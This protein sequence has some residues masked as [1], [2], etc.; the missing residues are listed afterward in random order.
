[1]QGLI[2]QISTASQSLTPIPT[3]L[4]PRL[5]TIPSIRCV[6]F[7]VYGTLMVSGVGDISHSSDANRGS[8]IQRVAA[9]YGISWK[10]PLRDLG[11]SFKA[12]IREHHQILKSKGIE[13][14]EIDIRE[15][16]SDFLQQHAVSPSPRWDDQIEAISL[17]FELAVNPTWPM[18]GLASTLEDLRNRN[19]AL[20]IVS[21]AQFFTPLLF[22]AYLETSLENLGFSSELCQWSYL[23]REAKPSTTLY[24]HNVE[25]LRQRHISPP[26]VLYVGNDML[27]DVLPAQQLGFRTALFAGDQR[28][29]RLREEEDRIRGIEP[30]LVIT[31]LRQIL[32]CVGKSA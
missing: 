19:V 15:V 10:E 28:S 8:A 24:A 12:I 20:G 4:A 11:A 18:P 26:E 32:Q 13:C 9:A 3:P 1:M 5:H 30:D 27:N 23:H 2:Q 17:D 22:E 21:N 7:D 31:E 29:L 16:W 6:L 25:A 14:P